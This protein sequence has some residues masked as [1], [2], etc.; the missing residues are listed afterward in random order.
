MTG[1]SSDAEM[2]VRRAG[3]AGLTSI[4]LSAELGVLPHSAARIARRLAANGLIVR[5]LGAGHVTHWLAPE[6][7]LAAR[8][9]EAE[10]RAELQR[11]CQRRN[12]AKYAREHRARGRV[13]ETP[14]AREARIEAEYR[15]FVHVKR[16]HI[17]A[18]APVPTEHLCI[19]NSV[20][21]LGTI[22]A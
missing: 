17:P 2:A 9:A 15:A 14:E 11:A 13:Q 12:G 3:I 7:S 6:C 4:Q 8:Q 10:R 5:M 22:C 1:S 18:G 21:A 16:C 19:P 20:F